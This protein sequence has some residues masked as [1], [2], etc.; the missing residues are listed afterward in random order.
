MQETTLAIVSI[1]VILSLL[2]V[3][4]VEILN[5]SQQVLAVKL[6]LSNGCSPSGKG[7]DASSGKC[8]HGIITNG[9]NG[10]SFHH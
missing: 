1:V 8:S 10:R 6:R 3:I 5:I 7:F 4:V 9:T 2:G